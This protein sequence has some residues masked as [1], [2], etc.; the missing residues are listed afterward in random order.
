[1]K[2]LLLVGIGGFFGTILR[3]GIGQ[4]IQ[5]GNDTFPYS[6]L[7]INVVGSFLFGL[8]MYFSEN[9][10]YISEETR[11]FLTIGFMGAFTT[12][13]TFSFES[14]KMIEKGQIL[15]LT[16]YIVATVL[17][18]LLAVYLSRHISLMVLKQIQT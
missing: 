15:W 17:L 10:Q 12:M 4:L 16:I 6:T 18:S 13:S 14:I 3:Y 5:N 7:I 8:T 1:M 9:F 2:L 11:I